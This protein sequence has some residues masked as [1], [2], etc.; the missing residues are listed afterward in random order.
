MIFKPK[1]RILIL[2]LIVAATVVSPAQSMAD[3][4]VVSSP[5]LRIVFFTPS[6]IEPPDG[7][8]ERLKESVDYAQQFYGKWLKHWGYVSPNPV[9]IIRD[10]NGLP[11]VLFVKGRHDESSGRYRQLGFEPEVIETA[12]NE[13][14]ID[15]SGQVWWIFIYRGP[16]RRGF[17]GGGNAKRGG[18]STSIYDPDATGQLIGNE[19]GSDEVP[20]N[21]K[22]SIHELGHA[23]GLP[24]I[25]PIQKDK[26]GNSL[27]GPIVKAFESRFPNEERVY[28]TEASAAM[29]WKHPLLSGTTKDRELIP[30]FQIEDFSVTHE[31]D[32]NRFVVSG[33]VAADY[34]AHSIV[35]ANESSANRS[36]YWRKCFAGRI[37]KNNTFRIEV[38][39]VD[40]VDGQLVL[41]CC[42]NNG[43]VVGKDGVGLQRGFVKQY[44]FKDDTFSV[45]A[46]WSAVKS[47]RPQRGQRWPGASGPSR[48]PNEK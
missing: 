20:Q 11:Q 44:H 19:L 13:Y 10:Q 5:V 2:S 40:R 30:K 15:P 34:P 25:G 17:R 28:L 47:I 42:F 18:T 32:Q 37:A 26:L 29:L 33:R 27:M 1:Q 9:P 6:D 3:D 46:G 31:A 21:S 12:C 4:E 39:E 36:D 16:Q 7:V 8:K 45:D 22:A 38:D 24:H 48:R 43:A 23:L 35:I 41:V 14:D